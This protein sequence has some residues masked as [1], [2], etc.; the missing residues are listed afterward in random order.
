MVNYSELWYTLVLFVRMSLPPPNNIYR[1]KET[2]KRIK[3]QRTKPASGV[4]SIFGFALRARRHRENSVCE[5]VRNSILGDIDLIFC[6]Y[7][8][9][10]KI[11]LFFNKCCVIIVI[12]T[13]QF[14]EIIFCSYCMDIMH[15][16]FVFSN[17]LR[18]ILCQQ[19]QYYALLTMACNYAMAFDPDNV[20]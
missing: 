8:L 12:D 2:G 19:T 10:F 17:I 5:C 11:H 3:N 9:P 6:P 7:H 15:I 18:H 20:C 4:L 1:P 16:Y 13:I 14:L